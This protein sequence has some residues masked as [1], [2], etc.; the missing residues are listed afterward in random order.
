[1]WSAPRRGDLAFMQGLRLVFTGKQL[2]FRPR[3]GDGASFC[4]WEVDWSS[5]TSTLGPQCGQSGTPAGSPPCPAPSRTSDMQTSLPCI[6]LSSHFSCRRGL[7]TSGCG[8][9]AAS[10][11]APSTVTFKIWRVLRTRLCSSNVVVSSGNAE[12]R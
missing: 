6:Q 9:G 8:A 12:S 7:P 10:P 5:R 11:S 4:F 1:M 2:L 3:V